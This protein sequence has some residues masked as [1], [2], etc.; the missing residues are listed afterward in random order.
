MSVSAHGPT[1]TLQGQI[2]LAGL[3]G[4]QERR[5]FSGVEDDHRTGRKLA[6]PHTYQA[7]LTQVDLNAI[8]TVRLAG[9]GLVPSAVVEECHGLVRI[10]IR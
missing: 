4:G 1:D 3:D 9:G 2:E 10:V 8:A 7:T 6:V 5:P